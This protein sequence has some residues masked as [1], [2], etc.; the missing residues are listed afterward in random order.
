DGI[1]DTTKIPSVFTFQ[2]GPYLADGIFGV[3]PFRGLSAITN[4]V[5]SSEVNILAAA[6][7]SEATLGIDPEVYLGVALQNAADPTIRLPEGAPVRPSEWLRKVAPEFA[8]LED[9]VDAA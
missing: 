3:G 8:E 6:Q 1:N 9:Q 4:A 2:T 5:H 7:L